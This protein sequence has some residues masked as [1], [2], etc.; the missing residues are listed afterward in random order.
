M[1]RRWHVPVEPAAMP[2]GVDPTAQWFVALDAAARVAGG[3]GHDVNNYL[4]AIR[5]YLTFLL[6]DLPPADPLR[7]DVEAIHQVTDRAGELTARLLELSRQPA[8][9]DGHIDLNAAIEELLPALRALLGDGIA[10]NAALAADLPPVV[11]SVEQLQH[12]LRPLALNARTAMPDGGR[13]VVR[14][15][16]PAETNAGT[17][18][19]SVIDTGA[20]IAAANLPRVFEPFFTTKSGKASGLGLT[21]AYR[22]VQRGGGAI[23]IASEVGEGTTVVVC[24]P[25]GR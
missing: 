19:L 20:G 18:E 2:D 15:G 13:L 6:E 25:T 17:V 9:V 5:G 10:V 21:S 22:I 12:L 11:S 3:V 24:L 16:L 7:A 8:P 1:S 23:R 14:T 4:T